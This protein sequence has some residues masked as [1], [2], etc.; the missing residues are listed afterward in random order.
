MAELSLCRGEKLKVKNFPFNDGQVLIGT[1]YDKIAAIYI[2]TLNDTK[3][4]IRV[5]IDF[6]DYIERIEF[7]EIEME[8]INR[9]IADNSVYSSLQTM[10][11]GNIITSNDEII[12]CNGIT[13]RNLNECNSN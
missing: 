10:D 7:L 6:S 5:E 8:I 1:V 12:I 11:D 9:S 2:D 13:S 3:E 4:P